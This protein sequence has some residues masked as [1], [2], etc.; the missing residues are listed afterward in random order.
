MEVRSWASLDQSNAS[1]IAQGYTLDRVSAVSAL[2][3]N[4]EFSGMDNICVTSFWE[5]NIK[6]MTKKHIRRGDLS[7]CEAITCG[8]GFYSLGWADAQ[9][10]SAEWFLKF[11]S[12]ERAAAQTMQ[13]SNLGEEMVA[14]IR[15]S[16]SA[17]KEETQQHENK[18]N[19]I[20][21]PERF[22]HYL[23]GRRLFTTSNQHIG[24]GPEAMRDGDAI[25]LLDGADTPMVLRQQESFYR[26]VGAAYI[27]GLIDEE[28]IQMREQMSDKLETFELR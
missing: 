23:R 26:V 18:R 19:I 22:R 25:T 24:L 5:T 2:C 27:S 16:I 8:G 28:G 3:W 12:A 7:F 6:S 15:G 17:V 13:N 1:L 10:Q 20:P 21:A 11:W 9:Q 4:E 14:S